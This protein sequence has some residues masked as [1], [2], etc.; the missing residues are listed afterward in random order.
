MAKSQVFC[1]IQIT[2]PT[3]ACYHHG[4]KPDPCICAPVG[5]ID[6]EW[7][8][9]RDPNPDD[10]DDYKPPYSTTGVPPMQVSG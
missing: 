8:A 5:K 2:S 1:A 4:F 3:E 10:Y 7:M 6:R 9:T